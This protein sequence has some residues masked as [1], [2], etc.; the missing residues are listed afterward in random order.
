[1]PS[2]SLPFPVAP[3]LLVHLK[4]ENEWQRE[5]LRSLA[6]KAEASEQAAL[7]SLRGSETQARQLLSNLSEERRRREAAEASATN[8]QG[9]VIELEDA[10]RKCEAR[11]AEVEG[12]GK[13]LRIELDATRGEV[14][15]AWAEAK[16]ARDAENAAEKEQQ[17]SEDEMNR[18]RMDMHSLE[19]RAAMMRGRLNDIDAAQMLQREKN[20]RNAAATVITSAWK[21]KAHRRMAHTEKLIRASTK[22]QSAWRRYMARAEFRARLRMHQKNVSINR[23]TMAAGMLEAGRGW[24]LRMREEMAQAEAAAEAEAADAEARALLAVDDTAEDDGAADA[25]LADEIIIPETPPDT[26]YDAGVLVDNLVANLPEE[27]S[28]G[29]VEGENQTLSLQN[30]ARVGSTVALLVQDEE[31][32]AAILIQSRYRRYAMKKLRHNSA[33]KIQ[34]GY[35]GYR[36]RC[37][38]RLNK[39]AMIGEAL[40]LGD[41]SLHGLTGDMAAQLGVNLVKRITGAPIGDPDLIGPTSVEQEVDELEKVLSEK[42]TAVQERCESESSKISISRTAADALA[43][44]DIGAIRREW[45]SYLDT[46]ESDSA[47]VLETAIESN[48]NCRD[49]TNAAFEDGMSQ[50]KGIHSVLAT[51]NIGMA[52][53]NALMLILDKMEENSQ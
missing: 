9:H 30:E 28:E 32:N 8:A 42:I 45:K 49:T 1:M 4:R 17:E 33:S 44:G 34:A 52:E 18:L 3:N 10:M 46:F 13:Q 39:P 5:Q 16:T 21:G 2:S 41:T 50:I 23:L 6:D 48:E 15:T 35:R 19:A 38:V 11:M 31:H 36:I 27:G 22:V 40:S 12:A 29:E 51:L 26:E 14:K 7:M 20:M 25:I 24:V 47:T 37:E 53:H 43:A